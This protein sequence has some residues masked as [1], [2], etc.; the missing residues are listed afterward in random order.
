MRLADF[1]LENLEPI[2]QSWEDFASTM[3]PAAGGMNSVELR[4]HAEQMLRTIVADL[5]TKQTTEQATIKSHGRGPRGK[6]DTAAETHALIR[7]TSGF[8][9]EQMVSEYRAL[10]ASVLLLWS[11]RIREGVEFELEDMVRFNEAIDQAL[12]E[13]V[14]RFANAVNESQ[15]LFLGILGHDLRTPL[16]AISLGAEVLLRDE[17]LDS[18]QT[19]IASRIYSSVGRARSIVDSLLDFTRSHFGGGIPVNRAEIDLTAICTGMVDEVRAYHPDRTILFKASEPLIGQ[20]D[21]ERMEQVFCNLIENA[22]RHGSDTTPI[23]VSLQAVPDGA[24][25]SA[26]N[27]GAPIDEHVLP[28]IFNPMSHYPGHMLNKDNLG[29][30]LGLGLHIAHEIV[31]AHGGKIEVE[32]TPD[33]GTTFTVT[34]PLVKA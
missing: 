8:T 26:H 21:A 27:Q 11:K 4:D 23:Q 14:V 18:R 10:R 29:S 20:F 33:Q 2:L 28:H 19:G 7:L 9:I 34:V 31:T 25:F 1:I 24:A 30:G 3:L 17:N 32:S 5:R 12:A 6:E 15:H 22:V 13:S 16:G